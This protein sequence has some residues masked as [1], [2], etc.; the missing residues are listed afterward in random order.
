MPRVVYVTSSPFSG[1]TLLC[2]LLGSHPDV[3]AAGELSVLPAIL[4]GAALKNCSCGERVERCEFWRTVQVRLPDGA[5]AG[6]WKDKSEESIVDNHALFR[7]ISAANGRSR[8]VV[9]SSKSYERLE[10]LLADSHLDVRVIHLVRDGRAVAMSKARAGL[11]TAASLRQWA[12]RQAHLQ[13]LLAPVNRSEIALVRYEDLVADPTATIR[14]LHA[15]MGVDPSGTDIKQPSHQHAC[16]G[17]ERFRRDRPV[18]LDS[19]FA[20]DYSPWNWAMLS[21]RNYRPLHRYG[22]RFARRH[23]LPSVIR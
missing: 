23:Y 13:E 1:S 11:S 9:D 22:Y 17:N 19:R 14:K 21:V 5:I 8:V 6:P 4:G 3:T 18:R 12:T 20:E 10:R 7:A 15:W 2:H 16:A